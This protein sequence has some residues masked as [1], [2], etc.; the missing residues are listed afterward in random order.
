MTI[1]ERNSARPAAGR[2][3]R[4][5]SVH[6]FIPH[7]LA[8]AGIL[9]LLYP[10]I[11]TLV[12][13]H[14]Q[15]GQAQVYSQQITDGV[16][17]AERDESIEQAHAWNREHE[18]IPILD[19]WLTRITKD[20]PDY[21][22]YLEQLDIADSMGRITIPSIDSDLPIYHG[23]TEDVLNKG[24]GHLYGSSLPVGGEGTHAVMTGHTGLPGA[25]LWDNLKDIKEGQAVYLD[26]A[27]QKM[28]YEVSK[29]EVVLPDETS[30]LKPEPGIDQITLVTCTPYGINS[31][32]LLVTAHRVPMDDEDVFSK[33][34]SPWQWWMT[35]ALCI[36]ALVIIL[37]LA[38]WIRSRKKKKGKRQ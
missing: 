1:V 24:I 26:V 31:H 21:Q 33:T 10:V 6:K 38:A 36:V 15:T 27:G 19:P 18:G 25:T 30:K 22:S 5:R 3:R 32:R 20:N 34:Y 23:T 14:R 13:N 2:H 35:A 28:K 17:Q 12:Q 4:K 8:L 29:K 9:L 16:S 37:V 7:L 11:G